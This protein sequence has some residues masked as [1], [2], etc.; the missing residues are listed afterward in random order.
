MSDISSENGRRSPSPSPS[1]HFDEDDASSSKEKSL[2]EELVIG[3]YGRQF[4]S[5]SSSNS[6][7]TSLSLPS[8]ISKAPSPVKS[9]SASS[10]SK[11]SHK[12]HLR[13]F[14]SYNHPHKNHHHHSTARQPRSSPPSPDSAIIPSVKCVFCLPCCLLFCF[15]IISLTLVIF[16]LIFNVF[17]ISPVTLPSRW[18]GQLTFAGTYVFSDVFKS[19]WSPKTPLALRKQSSLPY[20]FAKAEGERVV[21]EKTGNHSYTLTVSSPS[22]KGSEAA[23]EVML[24]FTEGVP[25]RVT[26]VVDDFESIL[27]DFQVVVSIS[28]TD[29]LETYEPVEKKLSKIEIKREFTRESMTVSYALG[30]VVYVKK[31]EKF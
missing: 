11:S 12:H 10:S 24:N 7:L 9:S 29:W 1:H 26:K 4:R 25:V 20:E 21:I 30:K 5:N 16:L 19:D 27:A 3:K 6:S 28:G 17:K 13:H 14:H 31:Y 15:L 8:P 18:S 2:E 22:I 23:P